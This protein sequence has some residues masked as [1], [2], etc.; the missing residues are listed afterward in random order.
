MGK[1]KVRHDGDRSL[2]AHKILYGHIKLKVFNIITVIKRS[3]TT[4]IEMLY[5]SHITRY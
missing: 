4:D 1:E 5:S 2:N 3:A